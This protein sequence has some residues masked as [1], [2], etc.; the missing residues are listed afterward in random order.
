M[1]FLK[2]KNDKLCD[3]IDKINE[4]IGL[5]FRLILSEPYKSK[6]QSVLQIVIWVEVLRIEWHKLHGSLKEL[7]GLE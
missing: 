1:E 2:E 6:L 7:S 4:E 3:V 5:K